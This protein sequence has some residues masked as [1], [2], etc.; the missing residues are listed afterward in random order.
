MFFLS[1]SANFSNISAKIL[2][3][4][5]KAGYPKRNS[6]KKVLGVLKGQLRF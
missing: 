3:G 2:V 6:K 1:F 4:I 5:P